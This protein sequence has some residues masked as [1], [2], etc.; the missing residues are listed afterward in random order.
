MTVAGFRLV[1]MD[2]SFI[3]YEKP[4]LFSILAKKW[5]NDVQ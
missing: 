1:L 2:H 5:N 4:T 3:S